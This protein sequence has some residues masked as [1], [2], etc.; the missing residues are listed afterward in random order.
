MIHVNTA[1]TI[2]MNIIDYLVLYD[3]LSNLK[4]CYF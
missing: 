2:T 1:T 3:T 4:Y